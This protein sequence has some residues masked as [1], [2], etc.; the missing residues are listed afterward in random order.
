M[1][2]KSYVCRSYRGKT[3]RGT[4][5]PPLSSWIGLK[6]FCNYNYEQ[7]FDEKIKKPILNIYK[8]SNHDNNKV[9]LLFW[10]GAY[11][12]EYMDDWEKLNGTSLPKEDFY[13]HLDMD[14]VTDADYAYAN[15][16][17]KIFDHFDWYVQSDTLLLPNAYV[18]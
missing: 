8:S 5:L 18:S 14:D 9:I 3:G 10:K 17:V 15:D 4:F 11:P 16:S 7:N 13:S 6:I 1:G 2:A 12:Y